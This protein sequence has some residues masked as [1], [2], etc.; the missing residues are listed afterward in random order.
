M[1]V[2]ANAFLTAVPQ[3]SP[4][5]CPAKTMFPLSSVSNFTSPLCLDTASAAVRIAPVVAAIVEAPTISPN[6]RAPVFAA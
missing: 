3:S 1:A 6:T 4:L 2:L 5:S